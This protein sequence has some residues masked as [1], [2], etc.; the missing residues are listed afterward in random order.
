MRDALETRSRGEARRFVMSRAI[1][2]GWKRERSWCGRQRQVGEGLRAKARLSSSRAGGNRAG[3]SVL[4]RKSLDY[5]CAWMAP[6]PWI[7]QSPPAKQDGVTNGAT[8]RAA[9]ALGLGSA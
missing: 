9:L 5:C 3:T 8:M 2:T 6:D 1:T 4:A 7:C